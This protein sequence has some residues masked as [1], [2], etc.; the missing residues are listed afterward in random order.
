MAINTI[1]AAGSNQAGATAIP[2]VL[3]G[4]KIQCQA[5]AVP[6]SNNGVMLP[7]FVDAY[8]GV[9]IT[10][11]NTDLSNTMKV[12]PQPGGTI[13]GGSPDAA[14]TI[15]AGDLRTLRAFSP[16]DWYGAAAAAP[17]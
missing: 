8:G 1:S 10:L 6:S 9:E 14:V 16:L 3:G 4:M 11:L 13:N 7:A 17:G 15:P 12:Y 5:V 2:P